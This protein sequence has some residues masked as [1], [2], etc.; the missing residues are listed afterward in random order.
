MAPPATATLTF[1][2]G[3]L[4]ASGRASQDWMTRARVLSAA[5]PGVDR[6]LD[7]HL[8][9]T[10]PLG[11]MR[12]KL[13]PPNSVEMTLLGE[14]LVL[15]GSAPHAWL[16]SVPGRMEKGFSLDASGVID[17][18]QQRLEKFRTLLGNLSLYFEPGTTTFRGPHEPTLDQVVVYWRKV[19]ALS[20]VLGSN[21]GLQVTGQSDATGT[22]AE[23]VRL[24]KERANLIRGMLIQRGLAESSLSVEAVQAPVNDPRLR[25]V[26]FLVVAK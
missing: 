19:E 15:S 9:D 3:L 22:R 26:I 14:E 24:S 6:Y 18:E 8:E 16:A 23:N 20:K 1:E 10:D 13:S 17:L 2:H 4:T 21:L 7:N 5:L 12:K 25:R 11:R